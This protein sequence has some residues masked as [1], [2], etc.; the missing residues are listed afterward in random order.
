MHST[1]NQDSGQR[2]HTLNRLNSRDGTNCGP[3]AAYK[4]SEIPGGSGPGTSAQRSSEQEAGLS[5]RDSEQTATPSSS[6]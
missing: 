6:L 3:H 4:V 2:T 1:R 5:S